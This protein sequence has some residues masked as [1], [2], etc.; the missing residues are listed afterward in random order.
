MA[1]SSCGHTPPAGARFCNQC[2]GAISNAAAPAALAAASN[3]ASSGT[4]PAPAAGAQT[5]SLWI[6]GGVVLVGV[7]LVA[8]YPIFSPQSKN[9][10]PPQQAV[11]PSAS[12]IDLTTMTPRQAADRLW[13]RVMQA[14]SR[15]DTQEVVNF[16][17]MAI[18]AYEIVDSLDLDGQYHL[19]ALKLEGLDGAGA[20]EVAGAG[21]EEYP[22]HLLLL[23]AAAEAALAL[24][25]STAARTFYQTM[26]D[27]WD[28]ELS[29]NRSDY[30]AHA[31]M[32][33]VLRQSAEALLGG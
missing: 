15:G 33:P 16:L 23:G 32:Q 7:M 25:D 18:G 31:N 24:E 28:A 8:L 27:V 13:E 22:N 4:R 26:L 11:G 21:L 29:T 3:V 17:P 2:G 14:V 19:S 5:N 30:L 20:L 10:V 12:S 6:V 1:C 9:L